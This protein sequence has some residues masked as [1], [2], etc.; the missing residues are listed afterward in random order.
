MSVASAGELIAALARGDLPAVLGTAE[1]SWVDFKS[2]PYAHEGGRLSDRGKWD[3]AKDVACFANSAGGLIVFGFGTAKPENAMVEEASQVTPIPKALVDFDAY[4]KVLREWVYPHVVG[5][6]MSWFPPEHTASRGVF[7][8]EIPPQPP[9]LKPFMVRRSLDGD[10]RAIPAWIVHE[11]DG[12]RCEPT[13]IER[14]HAQM[15][16]GRMVE[17]LP[18]SP[19]SGGAS[20]RLDQALATML[21]TIDGPGVESWLGVVSATSDGSP[22]KEFYR[23]SGGTRALL[24]APPATRPHG[25]NLSHLGQVRVDEGAFVVGREDAIV[26]ASP[27]GTFC[28]LGAATPDFLGWGLNRGR[29][30]GDPILLNPLAVVEFVFESVR[31]CEALGARNSVALNAFSW[32]LAAFGLQSANVRLER[33]QHQQYFSSRAAQPAS[34]DEWLREIGGSDDGAVV[35]FHLLEQLY[36]LFGYASDDIPYTREGRVEAQAILSA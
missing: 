35:A 14:L 4:A 18:V 32:R 31:L 26:R 24:E 10:G 8:I 17:S 6:R 12:D 19:A 28:A 21:E 16:T 34:S 9:N 36:A 7:V 15:T 29:A 2:A 25:F 20:E 27:D 11:R 23:A 1:D 5:V 22:F 13:P 30:G 3:L 33:G